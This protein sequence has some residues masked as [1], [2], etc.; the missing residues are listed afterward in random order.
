MV[1]SLNMVELL[2]AGL[3][4]EVK[5]AIT[6]EIVKEQLE[7]FEASIRQRIKPVVNSISF[8]GIESIKD[9]MRLREELHV[10]LHYSDE[11][12]EQKI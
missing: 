6:E 11:V 4:K 5:H 3:E 2:R 8:K 12:K 1:N 10:Y 9:A 7:Q